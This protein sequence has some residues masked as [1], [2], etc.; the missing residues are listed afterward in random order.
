MF[1]VV[2][3]NIDI[4]VAVVDVVIIVG[5]R[6]LILKY[7]QNQVSKRFDIVFVVLLLLLLLMMM[8]LLFLLLFFPETFH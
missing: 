7:G 4:V 6:N 2:D 1:V 3:S 5:P 8:L